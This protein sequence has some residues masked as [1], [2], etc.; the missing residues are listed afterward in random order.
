MASPPK[1]P[2]TPYKPA[3]D[4]EAEEAREKERRR[5]RQQKGAGSTILA[6]GNAG[7]AGALT[8]PTGAAT[9]GGR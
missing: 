5:L 8:A 9:L 3:G 2:K 1:I 7:S 4:E 6:G